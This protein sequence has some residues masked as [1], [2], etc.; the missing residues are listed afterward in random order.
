MS[1]GHIGLSYSLGGVYARPKK[2]K[3]EGKKK[4]PEIKN[5]NTPI[6]TQ[7]QLE[8]NIKTV[9][10]QETEYQLTL[11]APPENKTPGIKKNLEKKEKESFCTKEL[12][13]EKVLNHPT[14]R[15]FSSQC[16]INTDFGESSDY[17]E[18]QEI[19]ST[20]EISIQFQNKGRPN[21]FPNSIKLTGKIKKYTESKNILSIE[22]ILADGSKDV[23]Y[24]KAA[25]FEI[26]KYVKKNIDENNISALELNSVSISS[27]FGNLLARFFPTPY[28]KISFDPYPE[29]KITFLYDPNIPF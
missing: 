16:A 26:L 5:K 29:L 21:E 3:A 12:A 9:I 10:A 1:E 19:K 18:N 14:N 6:I 20:Q 28:T 4:E 15:K 13:G 27:E 25:F 2:V 17:S 7:Q 24:N 23:F 22:K 11:T 8:E